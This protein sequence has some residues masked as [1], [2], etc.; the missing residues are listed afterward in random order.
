MGLDGRPTPLP[1]NDGQAPVASLQKGPVGI[2][3]VTRGVMCVVTREG[4]R[5]SCTIHLGRLHELGELAHVIDQFE[6]LEDIVGRPRVETEQDSEGYCDCEVNGR[7]DCAQMEPKD[8]RMGPACA[9]RRDFVECGPAAHRGRMCGNKRIWQGVT[10]KVLV[11]WFDGMELGLRADEFIGKGRIVG[12]YTGIL[13]TRTKRKTKNGHSYD[14]RFDRRRMVDASEGGSLMRYVNTSCSK[15]NVEI[16]Q[17]LSNGKLYLI[18]VAS[19]DI[20]HGEAIHARAGYGDTTWMEDCKCGS[21]GCGGALQE[22][23]SRAECR[24]RRGAR[25][26]VGAWSEAPSQEGG[27]SNHTTPPTTTASVKKKPSKSRTQRERVEEKETG[28]V[29]AGE[30]QQQQ[31]EWKVVW[32]PSTPIGY[33][34]SSAGVRRRALLASCET[35]STTCLILGPGAAGAYEIRMVPS[36]TD[37]STEKVV[38]SFQLLLNIKNREDDPDD[39]HPDVGCRCE[40]RKK[41]CWGEDC[42]RWSRFEECDPGAHGGRLCWNKRI[43]RGGFPDV[44]VHWFPGMGLGLRTEEPI[45]VGRAVGLFTGVLCDRSLAR[46]RRGHSYLQSFTDNRNVDATDSG[47]LMRYVNVSCE[48]NVTLERWKSKGKSYLIYVA[49]ADIPRGGAIH[50]NF[51]NFSWGEE[52]HCGAEQC[53]GDLAVNRLDANHARQGARAKPR[54]QYV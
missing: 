20:Y 8:G 14:M 41:S 27:V 22:L 3:E 54:S 1:C 7:Q 40:Y 28:P 25:D 24:R 13:T 36:N 51:G 12:F 5:G 4:E 17:W 21:L 31:Q 34:R 35:G 10:A 23:P 33:Q 37:W 18:Y 9:L 43:Q 38:D 48:P 49:T 50:T 39:S 30:Q 6:W 45:E 15:P 42:S 29:H 16:E 46:R 2:K 52:C 11:C 53:T 19:E 47:S 32:N 44:S 26:K